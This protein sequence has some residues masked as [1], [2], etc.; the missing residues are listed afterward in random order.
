MRDRSRIRERFPN[1]SRSSGGAGCRCFRPNYCSSTK[2]YAP[3]GAATQYSYGNNVWRQVSFNN[4]LQPSSVTDFDL[5][6]GAGQNLLVVSL[7]WG[8]TNNNGN[9]QGA[10]YTHWTRICATF[11]FQPKL[12]LRY[13]ESSW[14]CER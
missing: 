7:N 13:S 2:Q 9:L 11:D 10:S 5:I 12:W 1:D 6:N 3:H 14:V 4:R 8:S